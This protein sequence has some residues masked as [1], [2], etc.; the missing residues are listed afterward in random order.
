MTDKKS[1]TIQGIS[2]D[3]S[4]KFV[5]GHV[6]TA[7]EAGALNQLR[8]EN[9][10]NNFAPDVRAAKVAVAADLGYFKEEDGKQVPDADQVS[11]DDLDLDALRADFAAYEAEYEFGAPR[12]GGA[13]RITDP[14]EREANSIARSLIRAA[15][16]A[17]G[18]KVSSIKKDRMDALVAEAIRS[19]PDI[20]EEAKRRVKAAAEV[21]F[22][23]SI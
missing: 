10:R 15:A 4:P 3:A 8:Y 12:T 11:T 22:D 2:F 21:N 23:L 5:E 6:L 20:M 14:V 19:K 9:L 13:P 7:I 18:I 17:K 16:Q 1:I